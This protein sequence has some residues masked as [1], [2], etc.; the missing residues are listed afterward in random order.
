MWEGDTSRAAHSF[1][2][3][4]R[5]TTLFCSVQAANRSPE[6]PALAVYPAVQS[7]SLP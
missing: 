7:I 3:F 4:V 5:S 1:T 2:Y 6:A